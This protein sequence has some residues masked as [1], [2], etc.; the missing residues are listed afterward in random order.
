MMGRVRLKPFILVIVFARL[1]EL[2]S[3]KEDLNAE[4]FFGISLTHRLLPPC[5]LIAELAAEPYW[6]WFSRTLACRA[7]QVF[8]ASPSNMAVLGL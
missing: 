8:L 1:A 6:L 7:S 4:I 3:D 2:Q 5:L